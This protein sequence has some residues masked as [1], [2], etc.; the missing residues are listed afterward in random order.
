MALSQNSPI[1]RDEIT[2]SGFGSL[3]QVRRV[4]GMRTWLRVALENFGDAS[5]L[6]ALRGGQPGAQVKYLGQH[7]GL[8]ARRA[9][10]MLYL[11]ADAAA[12]HDVEYAVLGQLFKSIDKL[13]MLGAVAIERVRIECDVA[14][15][16]IDRAAVG[17]GSTG[18]HDIWIGCS[19]RHVTMV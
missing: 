5:A 7:G 16:R 10:R 3:G 18:L 12:E 19:A 14:S 2:A 15:A 6:D 8:L 1:V 17:E 9:V 11:V 4:I 13:V